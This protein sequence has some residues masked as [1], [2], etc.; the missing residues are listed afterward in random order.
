MEIDTTTLQLVVSGE[1]VVRSVKGNFVFCTPGISTLICI[2]QVLIGYLS[3]PQA[4][5][6]TP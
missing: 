1:E 3:A 2:M 6:H 4:F 5:I